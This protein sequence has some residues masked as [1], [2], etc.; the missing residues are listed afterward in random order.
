MEIDVWLKVLFGV[1]TKNLMLFPVECDFSMTEAG[2]IFYV[3]IK[4]GPKC[5]SRQRNSASPAA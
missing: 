5:L 2:S 1:L 4:Y 3:W